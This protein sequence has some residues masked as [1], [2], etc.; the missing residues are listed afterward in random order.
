MITDC[1]GR[2]PSL[3]TGKHVTILHLLH[4]NIVD[5]NKFRYSAACLA[6]QHPDTL[7]LDFS[8]LTQDQ[9]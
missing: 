1:S 2:I 9:K 7:T 8:K 6:Q 5:T 4:I 3:R